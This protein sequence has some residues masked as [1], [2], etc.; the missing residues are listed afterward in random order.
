M[1]LRKLKH[2][3]K[4]DYTFC[5][6]CGM[7]EKHWIDT[8]YTFYTFSGFWICPKLYSVDGRRL[9]NFNQL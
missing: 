5:P 1:K 6:N 4:K 9:D 7:K 2:R 3:S 8:S